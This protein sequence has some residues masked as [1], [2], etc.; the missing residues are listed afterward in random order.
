MPRGRP[1]ESQYERDELGVNRPGGLLEARS[2]AP[3]LAERTGSLTAA[4]GPST[5]P[6]IGY[7][8]SRQRGVR[9]LGEID[10]GTEDDRTP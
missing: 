4:A 2:E 3:V 10:E 8:L 5:A 1:L 6:T 9:S 7:D